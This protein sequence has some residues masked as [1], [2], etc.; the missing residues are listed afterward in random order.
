M[1]RIVTY[2]CN[3]V[4]N[5][6]EIVKSLLDCSDVVMLQ[7]LMLN[8]DDLPL[9]NDIHKDFVNIAFVRE[10][11]LNGITEGRPRNGVA[12]FW[13]RSL[14]LFMEPVYVND[15]VIGVTVCANNLSILILNVYMPCDY[16]T[17]D[18][19]DKFRSKL[20]V[21]EV[22]IKEKNVNNVILAGDFNA[23]PFKGR[24]WKELNNFIKSFFLVIVDEI[25]PSNFIYLS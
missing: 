10:R 4:R 13:R 2:N 24:F 5:N 1:I 14:S 25:L 15:C 11:D 8:K 16:Q 19:L 12:M 17:Y 22:V 3:S 20:A 23:D 21:L 6:M 9:L 7:E 18:A